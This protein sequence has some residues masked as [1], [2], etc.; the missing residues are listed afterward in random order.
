MKK[1]FTRTLEAIIAVLLI[2]GILNWATSSIS[3]FSETKPLRKMGKEVLDV[4]ERTG[5]LSRFIEDYDFSALDSF[6]HYLLP[7]SAGHKLEFEKFVN[8]KISEQSGNN[9]SKTIGFTYNFPPGTKEDSINIFVGGYSYEHNVIWC[10]YMLPIII[11]VGQERTNEPILLKNINIS[12][13]YPIWNNSVIV[14][15]NGNVLDLKNPFE[16]GFDGNETHRTIN[17]TVKIDHLAANTN[18]LLF[19]LYA[20]N[21]TIWNNTEHYKNLGQGAEVNSNFSYIK[22]AN[23]ADVLLKIEMGGGEE[24]TAYM[25][26]GI[27]GGNAYYTDTL[28]SVNNTDISIELEENEFKQGTEP[29][30][31]YSPNT[32]MEISNKMLFT[33]KGLFKISLYTWYS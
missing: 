16:E 1:G 5:F 31:T 6:Y 20:D 18:E 9:I 22:K 19:L 25:S 28:K 32:D 13:D 11:N 21:R 14:Y 7:S 30:F 2:T 4:S 12:A 15:H 3:S 26:Y 10:W 17:L 29:I 33:K 27:N 23:R 24:K 8:L